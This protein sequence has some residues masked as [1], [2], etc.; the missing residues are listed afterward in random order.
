MNEIGHENV[1]NEAGGQVQAQQNDGQSSRN[2]Q[3]ALQMK[4]L[5]E[6]FQNLVLKGSNDQSWVI[7][8]NNNLARVI[9]KV[10]QTSEQAN[11]VIL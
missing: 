5:M 11:L 6:I 9:S 10:A 8:K 1:M 3:L 2:A 7:E 4:E